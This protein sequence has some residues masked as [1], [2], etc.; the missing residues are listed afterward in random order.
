MGEPIDDPFEELR[1]NIL[2]SFRRM[3]PTERA[4]NYM[5][6]E[7]EKLERMAAEEDAQRI[8]GE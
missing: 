6:F 7:I 8:R 1:R 3:T 5:P 4:Q 2:A